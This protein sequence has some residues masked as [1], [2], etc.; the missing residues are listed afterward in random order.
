M[1]P[2]PTRG[3]PLVT[4]CQLKFAS[5]MTTLSL[6]LVVQQDLKFLFIYFKWYLW[7]LLLFVLE[8][9]ETEPP[10]HILHE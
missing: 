8:L 6:T 7:I 10:F 1:A 9:L 2:L 3:A 5:L 4:A